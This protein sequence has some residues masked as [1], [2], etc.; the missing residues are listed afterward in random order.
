VREHKV[1]PERLDVDA[2]FTAYLAAI[3][4]VIQ[5]VDSL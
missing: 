2:L 1:K 4:K 5:A 3:E